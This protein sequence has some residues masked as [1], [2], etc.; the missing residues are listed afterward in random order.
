[1]TSTTL[2]SRPGTQGPTSGPAQLLFPVQFV[3][4]AHLLC[5]AFC[6]RFARTRNYGCFAAFCCSVAR[7]PFQA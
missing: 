1:M 4:H 6:P 7:Q 5:I 3:Q 2:P